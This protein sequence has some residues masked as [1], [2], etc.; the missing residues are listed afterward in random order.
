MTIGALRLT[1]AIPSGE[2]SIRGIAQ[3]AKAA[4]LSKFKASSSELSS[5]GR[6]Q[7]E[8]L[9]GAAIVAHDEKQA[10]KILDQIVSYFQEWGHADLAE[11]EREVIFFNDIE[12]ERDFQKYNP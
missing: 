1:F 12:L 2:D 3:K 4:L 8:L 5:P 9:I 6:Q 11:D 7:N 10:D